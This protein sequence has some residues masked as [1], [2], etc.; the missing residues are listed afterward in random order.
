[1]IVEEVGETTVEL[2]WTIVF[3]G[4][5]PIIEAIIDYSIEGQTPPQ[6]VT[7]PGSSPITV[8][9]VSL[10][11]FMTYNITVFLRNAVGTSSP[12]SVE[13]RTLSLGTVSLSL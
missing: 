5:T 9:L 13:A 11:P 8:T 1:M 2:S 12:A 3:D 7:V 4:R 10:M 6:R